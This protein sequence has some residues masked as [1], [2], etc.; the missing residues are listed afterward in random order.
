MYFNKLNVF[1][2]GIII[3]GTSIS[4][5]AQDHDYD[6]QHTIYS[7][8]G[9]VGIGTTTPGSKL[10]INGTIS[11]TLGSGG[12]LTLFDNNATRNNRIILGADNDGAFIRSTWSSGGTDAISF[13]N[14][15]NSPVMSIAANGNVG[16]G[17]NNTN[18]YR[19][20]IA[21]KAI[22]EE[23]KIALQPN[24]SDFVFEKDY[25][26]P[27]L[28]EVEEHIHNNGHLKDIPSAKEVA[29]NGFYLGEMDAKLLQKI[30]ELT[31]YT[32][33]QQ[34]EIIKQKEEIKSL[35]DD[36]VIIADLIE[37][38]TQLQKQV[39]LLEQK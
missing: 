30:E 2:F 11:N 20:A 8:N 34:K 37:K 32:I 10:E 7:L 27:T 36:K 15:V 13:R 16:I 23:I 6:S 31:L 17:T 5:N 28:Q 19:L 9:K 18:Q 29:R 21:G 3:S 24:W 22:A 33:A 4:I 38:L 26:L 12:T 39:D 14:S 35:K 1:L 25:Q